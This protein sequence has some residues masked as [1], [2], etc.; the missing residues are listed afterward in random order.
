MTPFSLSWRH[1]LLLVVTLCA[2]LSIVY[3][4]VPSNPLSVWYHMKFVAPAQEA[5]Y[6]FTSHLHPGTGCLEV[7][8][9]V[10]G[11]AFDSAGVRAGFVPGISSCFGFNEAELLYI[12][13]RDA[14]GATLVLPF[15]Q[16]GCG[17]PA[18]FVRLT[19]RVPPTRH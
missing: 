12:N 18:N 9:V 6:G 15:Y 17:A 4:F 3:F 8:S 10:P 13:L 7:T 14:R 11:G 5:R 19:V 2:L 1:W 16:G